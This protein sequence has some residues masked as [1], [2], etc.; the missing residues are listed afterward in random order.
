VSGGLLEARKVSNSP[1]DILSGTENHRHIWTSDFFN[2]HMI[3]VKWHTLHTDTQRDT[4]THDEYT[5]KKRS[6]Q[7]HTRTSASWYLP[8][9]KAM[10]S[11]Q[12]FHPMAANVLN[13]F[14]VRVSS[15]LS[16]YHLPIP[17]ALGFSFLG[18]FPTFKFSYKQIEW[19]MNKL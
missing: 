2:D 5:Y 7:T 9:T 19:T 16:W 17:R 4:G 12:M 8:C 6:T 11:S 1:F 15:M 13:V 14:A 3:D 18:F 10:P